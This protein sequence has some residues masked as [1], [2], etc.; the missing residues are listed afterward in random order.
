MIFSNIRSHKGVFRHVGYGLGLLL[1]TLIYY[2]A[3]GGGEKNIYIFTRLANLFLR[4]YFHFYL[5]IQGY[6][7][8]A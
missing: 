7:Q 6:M 1:T 4:M 5:F 3:L 8:V 2:G